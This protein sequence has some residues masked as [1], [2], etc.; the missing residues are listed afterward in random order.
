MVLVYLTDIQEITFLS[1]V[2]SRFINVKMISYYLEEEYGIN[3]QCDSSELG[4][5]LRPVSSSLPLG[6]HKVYIRVSFSDS[7]LRWLPAI[8][9]VIISREKTFPFILYWVVVACYLLRS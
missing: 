1:R 6:I 9:A 4:E 5:E 2:D 7:F 3:S 8:I